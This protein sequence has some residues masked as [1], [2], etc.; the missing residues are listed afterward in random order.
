MTKIVHHNFMVRR[1]SMSATCFK[2]LLLSLAQACARTIVLIFSKNE[3]SR[4][5]FGQTS[6]LTCFS[7]FIR[8]LVHQA[9][10]KALDF[11]QSDLSRPLKQ[12]RK[13]VGNN[14]KVDYIF[15]IRV[16]GMASPPAHDV[17]EDQTV[18]EYEQG[19][20]T[21]IVGCHVAQEMEETS[22]FLSN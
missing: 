17:D 7:Q 12:F 5:Q 4:A 20:H 2:M 11:H 21:F 8:Q 10:S 14:I 22:S 1:I 3:P 15:F 9:S 18:N 19:S 16:N 13:E 6:C